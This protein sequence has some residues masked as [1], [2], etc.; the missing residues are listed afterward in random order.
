MQQIE[1][2]AGHGHLYAARRDDL[3]SEHIDAPARK[4]IRL[5]YSAPVDGVRRFGSPQH[6]ADARQQLARIEGLDDVIV[7]PELQTQYLVDVL[8]LRRQYDYRN[9]S[10]GSH[11][12]ADRQ[13][14][15]AGKIKIEDQQVIGPGAERSVHC[16]GVCGDLRLDIVRCEIEG[17][18]LADFGVILDDQN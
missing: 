2:C 9:A 17:D 1:F 13:A 16:L 7:G 10:L 11:P 6:G 12:P 14:V 15:F 5:P 18:E 3:S 8:R 4:K